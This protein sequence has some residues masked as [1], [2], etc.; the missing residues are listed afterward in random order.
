MNDFFIYLIKS[1]ISLLVLYFG[2][3]FLFRKEKFFWFN[4]F[5]L[6]AA[7]FISLALPMVQIEISFTEN[8]K[9]PGSIIFFS[10]K[11]SS[12]GSTFQNSNSQ[13]TSQNTSFSIDFKNPINILLIGYGA[14]TII[15]LIR[16][17]IN[18]LRI[19][20]NISIH[21]VIKRLNYSLVLVDK[22]IIP[23]SFFKYIFINKND[24]QTQ[25]IEF[26]L[27]EHEKAHVKQK[28]SIDIIILEILQIIFWFNPVIIFY[29]RSLK[30]VHEYLADNSALDTYPDIASYQKKLLGLVCWNNSINLTSTFFSS[31]II[32]K[33]LA[34]MNKKRSTNFSWYKFLFLIPVL[35]LLIGGINFTA[36][37]QNNHKSN[38]SISPEERFTKETARITVANET[39]Q[40]ANTIPQDTSKEYIK[41]AKT[42]V[43]SSGIHTEVIFPQEERL[44]KGNVRDIETYESLPGVSI[45]IKGTR[46]GTIT[47]VSGNFVI[48]VD[49]SHKVLFFSFK[50]YNTVYMPITQS[51]KMDVLMV[52]EGDDYQP[53]VIRRHRQT[54]D[55]NS[56]FK[57]PL[58]IIDGKRVDKSVFQNLNPSKIESIEVQ[59]KVNPDIIKKFGK[60]AENGVIIVKSK[61]PEKKEK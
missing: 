54:F 22:N 39:A 55:I 60:E 13:I 59:K 3:Y 25:N 34:M 8:N 23:Y 6:L 33:R 32:K 14:G 18:L 10:E 57:E 11:I 2:Y 17:L 51:D 20:R 21:K 38:L 12:I 5:Y 27:I 28:H 1:S 4:R 43:R 37:S 31:K 47:D 19:I 44:I 40:I 26:Q 49:S 61:K 7:I 15:L 9:L 29:K 36:T 41:S 45:I 46:I 50:G 24:Y 35:I 53:T 56:L 16:F 30:M 58:Y 48:K 52:K 42:I